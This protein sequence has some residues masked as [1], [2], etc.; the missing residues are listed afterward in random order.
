M[1]CNLHQFCATRNERAHRPTHNTIQNQ[2]HWRQYLKC[3]CYYYYYHVNSR[4]YFIRHDYVIRTNSNS[5]NFLIRSSSY[6]WQASC[7]GIGL[8]RAKMW[9]ATS[10]SFQLTIYWSHESII[11]INN[12]PRLPFPIWFNTCRGMISNWWTHMRILSFLPV[13]RTLQAV[14]IFHRSKIWWNEAKVNT[15]RF[16]FKAGGGINL[17]FYIGILSWFCDAVMRDGWEW[18]I[19]LWMMRFIYVFTKLYDAPYFCFVLSERTKVQRLLCIYVMWNQN[20]MLKSPSGVNWDFSVKFR[21]KYLFAEPLYRNVI[22]VFMGE[23]WCS[24]K[25]EECMLYVIA[26]FFLLDK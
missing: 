1:I 14:S 22:Y 17:D 15:F 3:I 4:Y 7:I 5:I 25:R 10:S 24:G 18:F 8:P 23:N 6:I 19:W 13:I 9:F 2:L 21:I 20:W 16:Y 12:P 11:I 26:R